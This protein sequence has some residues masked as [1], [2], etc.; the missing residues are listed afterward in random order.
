MMKQVFL[1]VGTNLGNRKAHINKAMLMLK[2][3]VGDI[4]KVSS[5][6]ETEPW[7]FEHPTSFYNQ[8]LEIK[9]EFDPVSLLEKLKEIERVC[10]RQFS[11]EGYQAR[12][13]DLDI[14]FYGDWLV[15]TGVLKIPHPLAHL[16]RFV[17]VPMAEIAPDFEH[18]VLGRSMNELLELCTDTCKILRKIS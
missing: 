3:E 17:M 9:T 16:R 7:G 13:M 10:G 1:S 15:D 4:I 2:A 5:I 18:P 11:G 8:A 12:P 14:L 6:Y